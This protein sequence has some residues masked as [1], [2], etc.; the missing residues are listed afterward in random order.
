[1]YK[2]LQ[3]EDD[4]EDDRHRCKRCH[5]DQLEPPANVKSYMSSREI[6]ERDRIERIMVWITIIIITVSAVVIAIFC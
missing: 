2:G 3:T 5:P 4:A 6:A 1:M